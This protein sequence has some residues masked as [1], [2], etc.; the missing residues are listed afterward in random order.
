MSS[1]GYM[2]VVVQNV[3]ELLWKEQGKA[4]TCGLPATTIFKDTYRSQTEPENAAWAVHPGG[5]LRKPLTA[6]PLCTH[7]R[8]APSPRQ[9]R[10]GC[11]G[12][13]QTKPTMCQQEWGGQGLAP[14]AAASGSPSHSG[15]PGVPLPPG[16]RPAPGPRRLSHPSNAFSA[17]CCPSLEVARARAA[18]EELRHQSVA[19][20]A[21]RHTPPTDRRGG[22]GRARARR[23]QATAARQRLRPGHR[24]GPGGVP[25]APRSPA[26]SH[27][28]QASA[29]ARAAQALPGTHCR[30]PAHTAAPRRPAPGVP[31]AGAR[32]PRALQ[33][34]RQE[35]RAAA[36]RGPRR[37]R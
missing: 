10:G 30:S 34:G 13:E 29:P 12:S 20:M 21:A 28:P 3:P 26:A 19:L 23:Y 9:G 32:C 5:V 37:G 8:S 7:K 11:P 35:R 27:G 4:L 14:A 36:R 17:G 2:P 24:A 6:A 33:G 16:P 18:P 22:E 31:R 1:W 25:G 15:G